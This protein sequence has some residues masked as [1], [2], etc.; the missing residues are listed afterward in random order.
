MPSNI[1]ISQVLLPN[2]HYQGH[3]RY[4]NTM[5]QD[6]KYSQYKV[7]FF[8]KTC[9]MKSYHHKPAAGDCQRINNHKYV[10]NARIACVCE[11]GFHF[12]KVPIT[13][14][15]ALVMSKQ[16]CQDARAVVIVTDLS[17]CHI[18]QRVIDGHDGRINQKLIDISLS[19]Q[20]FNLFV[21]LI[22]HLL[23]GYFSCM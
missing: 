11:R 4:S 8:P 21:A 22:S 9:V 18:Q 12:H 20:T 23:Q 13:L 3:V 10:T 7:F 1:F 6:I 5:Q 17:S 14:V 2:S 19:T 16:S 15:N